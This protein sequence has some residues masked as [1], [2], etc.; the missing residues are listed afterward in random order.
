MKRSKRWKAGATQG[1]LRLLLTVMSVQMSRRLALL[2]GLVTLVPLSLSTHPTYAGSGDEP[3]YLAIAH[4]VAFDLDFDLSN[5][6]G[7]AEPLI[8][9]GGL[10]PGA[11]ARPGRDGILRPIHDVGMPL[12]AAPLVRIIAPLANWIALWAPPSLMSRL[13]LTPSGLY[14]H[15]LEAVVALVG[16][17]LACLLFEALMEAG[18]SR[19][20]AFWL[21]LLVAL[22]P[23]LLI[24]SILFFPEILSGFVA[25][26]AFRT[27]ALEERSDNGRWFLAGVAT[28]LLV[29]LHIRNIG[30]V[31]GLVILAGVRVIRQRNVST[32]AA[33]AF[34]LVALGA[35]RTAIN[36]DFW[37]TYLTNP[38]ARTGEWDGWIDLARTAGTRFVGLTVDQEFGL[39]VYA[40]LFVIAVVGLFDLHS[41]RRLSW[42]IGLVAGFY[43]LPIILPITNAHGWTGGWSPPARFMVPIVPILALGLV[44]GVRMLP[45][46][47]V[48]GI[49]VIQVSVNIYF[50]QHPKNLWNDG[51]GR[52]AICQRGGFRGCAYLP[53]IPSE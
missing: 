4:S 2:C 21:A 35:V 30:L 23:P 6:Y 27:L 16:A 48:V 25:L 12:L 42:K 18:A 3:H 53:S 24:Y 47:L 19:R 22:S 7:V 29:L 45:R 14:R 32:A 49:A 10:E 46:N 13:R 33:F 39:I 36:Y 17:A 34:P 11:H 15:L 28:G 51:D 5:N 31:A 40:P 44:A 9:D 41:S 38:H 52:A 37:G 43:L 26:I 8:G 1:T 20:R 50:W